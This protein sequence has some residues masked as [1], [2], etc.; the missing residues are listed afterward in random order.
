MARIA[1]A[2]RGTPQSAHKF[3]MSF[4][5]FRRSGIFP[6]VGI[7]MTDGRFYLLLA[8]LLLGQL[9]ELSRSRA[10]NPSI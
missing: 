1:R 2:V 5:R 8:L 6:G 10:L 9:D 4:A 7:R 3:G